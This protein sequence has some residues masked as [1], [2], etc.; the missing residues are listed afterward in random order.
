MNDSLL[1]IRRSE[2]A[3]VVVPPASHAAH[4]YN[5]WLQALGEAVVPPEAQSQ[6]NS[7]GLPPKRRY[8]KRSVYDGL[9]VAFLG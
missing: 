8:K 7:G 4:G 9:L 3:M 1:V 6:L 5:P 2:L